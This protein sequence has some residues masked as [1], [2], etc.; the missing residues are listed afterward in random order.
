MDEKYILENTIYR[1]RHGS[2]AYGTNIPGSDVDEKGIC[3]LP[4][5]SYYF[6][7]NRFEQKDGEWED[8][9]DRVIYDIR[10]FFKLALE[11]NPNILEILYVEDEDILQINTI[12]KRLR[13][14]RHLFL[15]QRAAKTFC[16]YASSQLHRIKNHYRWLQEPPK[17]PKR[18]DF[19]K[20]Q[21]F[22]TIDMYP[23]PYGGPVPTG[24][25]SGERQYQIELDNHTFIVH[26]PK[27]S[28]CGEWLSAETKVDHFDKQGFKNANKKFRQYHDW[29]KVL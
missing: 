19:F 21:L 26:Q 5:P 3:I 22:Q 6:G 18:E 4:D 28:S 13:D 2:R 1:V 17:E 10:K 15:S 16:G 11:A 20:T 8:G 7:F 25:S 29:I 23:L 24:A 9:N 12:G 27:F 14:N